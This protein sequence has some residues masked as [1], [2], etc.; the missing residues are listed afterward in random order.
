MERLI[1]SININQKKIIKQPDIYI[2]SIG[3]NAINYSIKIADL[4]RTGNQLIVMNDTLRRSP[5]SQMKEA[6][7]Y[8]AKHVIMIGDDEIKKDQVI[9][10][11]MDTGDQKN[12]L[13]KKL[14]N[15]FS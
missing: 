10:K 14:S 12:V 3:E 2:V 8:N 7:K 5:K 6:N 13:I 4:L 9:I 11:N 1:L 15:Y